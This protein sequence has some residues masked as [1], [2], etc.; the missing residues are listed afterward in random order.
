MESNS[1]IAVRIS[2]N[3]ARASAF[4]WGSVPAQAGSVVRSISPSRRLR[5]RF[6]YFCNVMPII[7]IWVKK[8][9]WGDRSPTSLSST[10][11]ADMA[12]APPLCIS[13][14][15]RGVLLSNLKN[16]M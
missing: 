1:G 6:R 7:E 16:E 11:V 3:R 15:N 12:I 14:R 5:G 8:Q 2:S 10:E 4:N 13:A 9:K